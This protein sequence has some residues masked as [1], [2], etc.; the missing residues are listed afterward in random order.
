MDP[1]FLYKSNIQ[2]FGTKTVFQNLKRK[3]KCSLD[4]Q[5]L[6][7]ICINFFKLCFGMRSRD[8]LRFGRTKKSIES[9]CRPDAWQHKY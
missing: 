8:V 6:L 9:V 1:S 5:I 3:K 2:K 4:D 7:W